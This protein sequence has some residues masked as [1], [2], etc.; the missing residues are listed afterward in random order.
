[1]GKFR[2][3]SINFR[4]RKE[5][6]REGELVSGVLTLE[7]LEPVVVKAVRVYCYGE[8]LTK[9]SKDFS[10]DWNSDQIGQEK[11]FAL[12]ITVVGTKVNQEGPNTT[13]TVGKLRWPFAFRLPA[14]RLPSS[15]EGEHGA[16]RWF[17]KVEVDKPFP[18]IN[19]KWYRAFTVLSCLDINEP[20]Y[21]VPISKAMTKTVSK[22]LGLGNAGTLRLS[23]KTDRFG[24]CC[25]ERI[26]LTMEAAN[27]SSK[28]MGKVS[29]SLI[30]RVV[31]TAND[32][33]K[34]T[35]LCLFP[36]ET[37][38]PLAKGTTMTLTDVQIPI[39]AV[40]PSTRKRTCHIISCTYQI[41]ATV[42]VP[43][44][45]NLDVVVPIAIGTI[46]RGKRA[47]PARLP[48]GKA[49]D[50]ASVINYVTCQTGI[51]PCRKSHNNFPNFPFTPATAVVTDSTWVPSPRTMTAPQGAAGLASASTPIPA[52]GIAMPGAI[53]PTKAVEAFAQPPVA[54][55]TSLTAVA[56]AGL[57]AYQLPSAPVTHEEM[58][59]PPSYE[60]VLKMDEDS[61]PTS[62]TAVASSSTSTSSSIA[63]ST[64]AI[65]QRKPCS[66]MLV[67]FPDTQLGS[68]RDTIQREQNN[69]LDT[70]E[71]FL[72]AL[73]PQP[74]TGLERP[75]EEWPDRSALAVLVFPDMRSGEEWLSGVCQR[76]DSWYS[77]C[78]AFI[79]P[80]Q[81]LLAQNTN[82]RLVFTVATI[83]TRPES[84]KEQLT[85]FSKIIPI[86][87]KLRED[88]GGVRTAAT[89]NGKMLHGKWITNE[90]TVSLTHWPKLHNYF[91]YMNTIKN[92]EYAQTVKGFHDLFEGHTV[93]VLTEDVTSLSSQPTT[94]D[95]DNDPDGGL[96]CQDHVDENPTGDSDDD[97]MVSKAENLLVAEDHFNA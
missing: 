53:P 38:T 72:A 10:R 20:V 88:S 13:L 92:G 63:A 83:R 11:Y 40:P 29:A 39:P 81:W 43:W 59:L 94:E 75:N 34:T 79:V 1:M 46:P 32:E 21:Q 80:A 66:I 42:H 93:L 9:W 45:L 78:D 85:S 26:I 14:E 90:Q 91:S 56:T 12:V 87:T 22:A 2:S 19:N 27:D 8:A 41:K 82:D 24:Y 58:G 96:T 77:C 17:L 28:D 62:P 48:A 54:A 70:A 57:P 3:C 86:F 6:Y 5:V 84:T 16:V 30:Q 50:P 73:A 31:F 67:R 60:D 4:D 74:I 18:S 33:S 68:F 36:V 37:E 55:A 61:R 71:A 64:A 89:K 52:A 15:I 44:G 7:V 49:L 35:D 65:P 25:G 76:G 51:V 95:V 97:D 69:L 47:P 23:V